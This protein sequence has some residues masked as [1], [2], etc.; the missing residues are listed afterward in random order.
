MSAV[1]RLDG[2]VLP[3]TILAPSLAATP[4]SRRGPPIEAAIN[5][6]RPESFQ[7]P[8]LELPAF[9]LHRTSAGTKWARDTSSLHTENL[10]WRLERGASRTVRLCSRLA[11]SDP[12]QT[13]SPG[14]GPSL[15]HYP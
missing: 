13:L 2:S 5:I 8:A 12:K 6:P 1:S 10:S 7:S 11:V 9:R 4:P 15:G 3:S 14:P